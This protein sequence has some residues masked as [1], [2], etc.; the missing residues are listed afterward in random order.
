MTIRLR[1]TGAKSTVILDWALETCAENFQFPNLINYH[2]QT[3]Q[4]QQL[5][6]STM[7]LLT[8]G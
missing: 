5:V 7:V 3:L 1:S 4:Y 2:Q 8:V 6:D